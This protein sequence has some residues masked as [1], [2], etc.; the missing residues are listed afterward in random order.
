MFSSSNKNPN[1]MAKIQE[2][3]TPSINIIGAGTSIKGDVIS[4]GDIRIDGTLQGT[5]KTKGKLIVGSNGN[6]EGEFYCTNGDFQGIINGKVNV[7][8]LLILKSTCKLSGEIN[9]NKLAIEPGA[10]FSGSCSMNQNVSVQY[11]NEKTET[12]KE[13]AK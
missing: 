6:V 4:N 7:S 3:E 5:V 8:E 12:S 2:V 10:V 13:S 9:T 11:K 1:N